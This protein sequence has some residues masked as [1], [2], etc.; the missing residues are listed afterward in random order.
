VS[1]WPERP[2]H[3]G[4]VIAVRLESGARSQSG[5]VLR[6]AQT[7]KIQI[8]QPEVIFLSSTEKPELW[9]ISKSGQSVQLTHTAGSIFDYGAAPDGNRIIYSAMNEK[10]GIDLWEIDRA[11]GSPRLLLPCEADW[12]INPAVSPDGLQLVYSRRRAGSTPGQ[13]PGV[14]H[15]WMFDLKTFATDE[16]YPDPNVGGFD[17]VWSPDGRYL[18]FFD[19]LS[20][21][22]RIFDFDQ[23][24]DT[25][26]PSK[27]GITGRWS[28]DS[29]QLLFSDFSQTD[30]GLSVRIF[31]VDVQTQQ[32]QRVMG[33]DVTQAEYSIPEWTPD[34]KEVAVALR[35]LSGSPGKQL[36]LMNP[37][38]TQARAITEDL[39]F[40]NASYSWDP[41]GE[42]LVFQRLEIG[43][44]DY[45][46]QVVVWNRAENS[47][48]VL[49]EDAH[50]PHW[51]P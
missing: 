46:P 26:L 39:L 15:L 33:D 47:L 5:L 43:G 19:G 38:G 36:W 40:T 41:A 44:S 20:G 2:F 50:Q 6:R 17:P 1:F 24:T 48:A 4:Q 8:R 51:L 3:P 42:N 29:R 45:Q 34:G 12:C 28:L 9:R 18:A 30:A 22:V 37:D 14:P 49:A 25:L 16:L 21:G 11:G 32:I 35:L 23:T 10:K 13:G 7:W 31:A 27:M